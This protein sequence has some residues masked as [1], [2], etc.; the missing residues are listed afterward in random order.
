MS[1]NAVSSQSLSA[2][3][4]P[5]SAFAWD[6]LPS[7]LRHRL[8]AS[9]KLTYVSA[10]DVSH[11]PRFFKA[12]VAFANGCGGYI[13]ID[14]VADKSP[15]TAEQISKTLS[16]ACCPA[17][18]HTVSVEKIND[19]TYFIVEIFPGTC[20]PYFVRNL[21]VT[22]GVYVV[23]GNVIIPTDNFTWK[24]LLFRGARRSF[25]RTV[26]AAA[27][28]VTQERVKALCD[29]ISKESVQN[30]RFKK[31][32]PLSEPVT[33]EH[34]L[35]WGLVVEHRGEPFPTF[36]FQLL[37]CTCRTVPGA[38]VQCAVFEDKL[39]PFAAAD[40][41]FAGSLFDQF[42]AAFEWVLKHLETLKTGNEDQ[43]TVCEIPPAAIR[44][45][46][47]NALCHR[48]YLAS[49]DHVTV[50]IYPD[51]LEITSPGALPTDYSLEKMTTGQAY[52]RN[53]A[54][55]QALTHGCLMAHW[56]TGLP[57]VRKTASV[58]GLK[59]P[60]WQEKNDSMTVIVRRPTSLAISEKTLADILSF[61][62][63]TNIGTAPEA[64]DTGSDRSNRLLQLV[65]SNPVITVQELMAGLELTEG[66]VKFE[67]KKLKLAGF[68]IRQ[69]TKK[70]RWI[71]K[72]H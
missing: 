40:Q 49:D 28:P 34:L 38:A 2:T 65:S 27:A 31:Y 70:G 35:T 68:L 8:D 66:Q 57:I 51:R 3:D 53:P 30:A 44:E 50:A 5:I 63:N 58:W 42:N 56:L 59:D 46:L 69:G 43:D 24:E 71:I 55:A 37:E 15:L 10:D 6:D 36:G 19:H 29:K 47:V 64:V 23:L 9:K 13:V 7:K 32:R 14:N 39:K 26:P 62:E 45:L 41:I 72:N 52:Y 12:V 17:A 1:S 60:V 25:D 18:D 33:P 20:T 21:G 22:E 67:L 11:D 61:N 48:S 16:E 54:I 4:S